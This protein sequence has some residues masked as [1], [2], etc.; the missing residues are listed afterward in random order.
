MHTPSAASQSILQPQAYQL[1]EQW[2]PCADFWATRKEVSPNECFEDAGL[3]AA[4]TPHDCN[5]RQVG[6]E[7]NSHL[8]GCSL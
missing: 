3:A 4:L 1:K 8:Q 5:L 7:V 6:C 2:T